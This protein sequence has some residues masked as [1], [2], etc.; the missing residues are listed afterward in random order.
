MGQK[1]VWFSN[2]FKYQLEY[3][4]DNGQEVPPEELSDA[5]EKLI[6]TQIALDDMIE[7][8][9]AFLDEV[10][11]VKHPCFYVKSWVQVATEYYYVT[12]FQG[13]LIWCFLARVVV[14]TTISLSNSYCWY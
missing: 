7:N 8:D 11:S 9:P 5:G 2:R 3:K 4:S 10:K 1:L 13:E 14:G 12:F 6:R